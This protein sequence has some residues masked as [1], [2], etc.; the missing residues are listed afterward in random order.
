M[1]KICM[2]WSSHKS[3]V[4]PSNTCTHRPALS[5]LSSPGWVK[6]QVPAE[7]TVAVTEWFIVL[8]PSVSEV[9]HWIKYCCM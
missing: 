8:C 5:T 6:P 1:L 9:P 4:H 7:V 2:N 3:V